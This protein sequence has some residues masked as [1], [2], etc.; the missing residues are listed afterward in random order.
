MGRK[1][2][3]F[4]G[5]GT[6]RTAYHL[7]AELIHGEQSQVLPVVATAGRPSPTGC[8][9]F[10]TPPGEI[11]SRVRKSAY[12]TTELKDQWFFVQVTY[13]PHGSMCGGHVK[14]LGWD[15]IGRQNGTTPGFHRVLYLRKWMLSSSMFFTA[16][17]LMTSNF[18]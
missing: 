17:V 5:T 4:C 12:K 8:G 2:S 18:V 9:S 13:L 15:A 1:L 3:R 6:P 16:T 10:L 7:S 11:G 14:I